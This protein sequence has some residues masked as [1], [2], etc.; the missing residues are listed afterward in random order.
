MVELDHLGLPWAI[1]TLLHLQVCGNPYK[2]CTHRCTVS[3]GFETDFLQQCE[4]RPSI[5]DRR[6]TYG[7]G[8]SRAIVVLHKINIVAET[9][10]GTDRRNSC[11]H[12]TIVTPGS[13]AKL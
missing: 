8:Q 7:N 9:I 12:T 11:S 5:V 2:G 4:H 13:N 1:R 10:N 6:W 3:S